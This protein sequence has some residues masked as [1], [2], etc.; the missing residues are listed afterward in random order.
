[1]TNRQAE[2]CLYLNVFTPTN[3]SPT[4]LKPVMV[5]IHGGQIRSEHRKFYFCS[6]SIF[7]LLGAWW[8]G[9]S[10]QDI[11]YGDYLTNTS[12][13][14]VVSMNYRLGA[15]GFLYNGNGIE[16]NYGFM[17][18]VLALQWVQSNIRHFGGDP[19]Q[20]TLFGQR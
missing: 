9:C 15:L 14:V 13:V 4:N 8:A 11:Y 16:G 18:Q 7:A 10:T 2:D 5:W 12:D 17:D 3:S 19:N 1:M 6:N 20:V